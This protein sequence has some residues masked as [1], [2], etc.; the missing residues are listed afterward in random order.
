MDLHLGLSTSGATLF[1]VYGIGVGF[2]HPDA[3][4]LVFYCLLIFP[5]PGAALVPR[6]PFYCQTIHTLSS[7]GESLSVNGGGL[8]CL[9][10]S[11]EITA[12][13]MA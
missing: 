1:F 11:A 6:G 10:K 8:S 9:C 5:W 12:D 7:L 2:H 3:R 13:P 4:M